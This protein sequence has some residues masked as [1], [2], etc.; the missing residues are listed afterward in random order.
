VAPPHV[1]KTQ[2]EDYV[3]M[4]GRAIE[5]SRQFAYHYQR[6]ARLKNVHFFDA[7]TVAKPDPID[8]V[9]LDARNSRALG[10]AL[11]PVVRSIL[12]LDGAAAAMS[13]ESANRASRNLGA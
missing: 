2:D 6:L 9:H 8:G 11:A 3:A 4:F 12:S 5:E 7:A 1:S 13:D 10:E